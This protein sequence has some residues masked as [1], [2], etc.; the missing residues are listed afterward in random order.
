MSRNKQIV[1]FKVRTIL[2]SMVSGYSF[3]SPQDVTYPIV[4]HLYSGDGPCPFVTQ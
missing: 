2:N 1:S 4:Q 3:C